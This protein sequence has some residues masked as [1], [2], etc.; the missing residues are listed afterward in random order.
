MARPLST[1]DIPHKLLTILTRCADNGRVCPS[2]ADLA[3]EAR[4]NSHK[5]A[6]AFFELKRRGLISWKMHRIGSQWIGRTVTIHA[7]GRTTRMPGRPSEAPGP[8]FAPTD[9]GCRVRILVGE[10][11]AARAAELLARDAAERARRQ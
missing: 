9:A 4:A 3:R 5:I 7:T 10:E 2:V 11:F 6:P 1:A 8:A